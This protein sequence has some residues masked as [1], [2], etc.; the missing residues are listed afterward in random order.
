VITDDD[1]APSDSYSFYRTPRKRRESAATNCLVVGGCPPDPAMIN[2]LE[3]A[4][5]Q[6]GLPPVIFEESDDN[7]API[8]GNAVEYAELMGLA[9]DVLPTMAEAE[10]W[11]AGQTWAGWGWG[12]K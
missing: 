7:G 9:P 6:L 5:R 10:Q 12:W 8:F 11:A 3:A 4:Y 1:F 2:K